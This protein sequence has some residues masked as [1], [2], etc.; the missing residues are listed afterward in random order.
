M[1]LKKG[2]NVKFVRGK[3]KGKTGTVDRVYAKEQKV[4]IPDVNVV[5]RHVKGQAGG[6]KSEILTVAKPLPLAN[7]QLVCPKCKVPTRVGFSVEKNG[8]VRVC[9]K[10]GATI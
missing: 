8:K 2:D 9:R 1:K 4:L 7:V 5:K 3:D 10:C 6:Q